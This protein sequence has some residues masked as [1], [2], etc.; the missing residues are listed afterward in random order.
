MTFQ[1][2]RSRLLPAAAAEPR[3]STTV[4]SDGF[5]TNNFSKWNSLQ[6]SSSG[7]VRNTNGAAYGGTG[8]YSGQIV[9]IDGRADVARFELR[10]GDSPFLGTERTEIGEPIAIPTAA[11]VPGDER[12]IAWD[13]KF[14]ATYPTTNPASDWD[15]G[16]QWHPNDDTASPAI[17]LNHTADDNIKL[18]YYQPG[19]NLKETTVQAMVR[20]T[21][22]RW[23][24]HVLF[25]DNPAVGFVDVWVDGVKKINH[26]LRATMID[27]D[28]GSYFKIGTYRDPVNTATSIVYVDNILITAP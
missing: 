22:Q 27:G 18:G 11:I 21:W 9:S 8:E 19:P 25:S 16:W 12:W 13:W 23:I 14:H 10:D 2:R 24:V 17:C 3:G 20:D 4:F 7:V 6:W 15:I 1:V 28:D 5:A 26:E